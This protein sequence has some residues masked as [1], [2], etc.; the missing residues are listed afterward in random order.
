M[1]D[2]ITF[3]E[4]Y[5]IPAS[6][7]HDWFDPR[8]DRDT[9]L[10]MDPFLVFK[11]KDPLFGGC[12]DKFMKFFESAFEIA[13]KVDKIP[14]H[15][16][17][18]RRNISPT[19]DHLIRNV[20]YF[21]EVEE[22]CLG[23]SERST[24]GSG[25]GRGFSAK[26]TDALIEMSKQ[27][28]SP[29]KHF[30]SIAIFTPGIGVDGISDATANIIKK[31]L[32]E[33]TMEVC[34]KYGLQTRWLPIKNFEF[35]FDNRRWDDQC[36]E[37][38][39]NPFNN[40][41]IILVPKRFLRQIP[42]ISPQE[43]YEYIES[44]SNE[45]IRANLN[46]DIQ[47]NLENND[48]VAR[49]QEEREK[50]TYKKREIIEYANSHPDVLNEFIEHVDD[51]EELYSAYNFKKDE[52]NLCDL[53]REVSRFVYRNALENFLLKN[54]SDLFD[55][56]DKLIL[57]VKVFVEGNGGYKFLWEKRESADSTDQ[58][59]QFKKKRMLRNFLGQSL[60]TTALQEK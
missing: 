34:K 17:R 57:Q 32:V 60:E 42:S 12:R 27:G 20:L 15:E 5:K 53:P 14:T 48:S 22:I 49:I 21:P 16:E 10:C 18:K 36:F 2:K 28:T 40:K 51:N 59:F 23:F 54:E 9:H 29:P 50:S 1:T 19:Y 31:E 25:A 7:N 13:S 56:I 39:F 55:F 8:L 37:L 46:F 41:P 3:S 33:Y 45:A 24:G 11:S 44:K 52:Q 47:A 38:P 58:R 30:E 6:D 26:V 4:L 35:D 43:F